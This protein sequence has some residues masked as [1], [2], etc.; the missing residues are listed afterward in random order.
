VSAAAVLRLTRVPVARLAR[1]RR[2]RVPALGWTLL[3]LVA[4]LHARSIGLGSG[5]DHVMRGPF[6]FVVVPLVSYTIVGAALGGAGLRGAT[7]GL[8]ALG[9]SSR[10][11]VAATVL[12][13]AI[14]SA[15]A[16]AILAAIVTVVAHGP[17]DA[18]LPADLV[19]SVGVAILGGAAY[20]AYFCAGSA[21]GSGAARGLFLVVDLFLGAG[22]GF[23]ALFT[24]RGHLMSLLGEQPCFDVSRRASSVVLALLVVVYAAVAVRLSRRP[25]PGR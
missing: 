25:A 19:A 3:T 9:A 8:V 24:P 7:R 5:A 12:V 4:S 17:I 13:A 2:G 23:G 10:A 1:T 22:A 14:A 15:I 11:A 18:P 21:I 16:S 20:A 6:G